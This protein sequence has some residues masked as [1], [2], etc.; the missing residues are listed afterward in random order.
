M[1]IGLPA[2]GWIVRIAAHYFLRGDP[3]LI[4]FGRY[5]VSR[6]LHEAGFVFQ[7]PQ[8]RAALADLLTRRTSAKT[9]G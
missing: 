8:L 3:E 1:P 9:S 5:V 2:A 6:R 7:F 4:L